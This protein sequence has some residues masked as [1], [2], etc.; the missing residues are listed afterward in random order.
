MGASLVLNAGTGY[1]AQNCDSH[2]VTMRKQVKILETQHSK[3]GGSK[4]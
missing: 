2:L 1:K 4:E 3:E